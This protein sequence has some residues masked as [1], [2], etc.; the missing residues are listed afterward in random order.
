MRAAYRAEGGQVEPVLGGLVVYAS[1]A[2]LIKADSNQPLSHLHLCAGLLVYQKPNRFFSSIWIKKTMTGRLSALKN[3][4]EVSGCQG[5]VGIFA[6]S[7]R[8]V[9]KLLMVLFIASAS[10]RSAASTR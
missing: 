9:I 1:V 3:N 7:S 6:M 4:A 2:C 8:V 5:Q 10:C